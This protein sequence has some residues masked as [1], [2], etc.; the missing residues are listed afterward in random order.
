MVIFAI[1]C[2]SARKLEEK[3]SWKELD[4]AWPSEEAKQEALRSGKYIVNHN[5]P[6]GLDVWNDKLFITVPRWLL[7][8]S[9]R[10]YC[11][12]NGWARFESDWLVT[13]IAIRFLWPIITNKWNWLLFSLR[14][15]KTKT[16]GKVP[17]IYFKIYFSKSPTEASQNA[18]VQVIVLKLV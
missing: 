2:A 5:L 11:R 8:N 7:D 3:F 10:W 9:R 1:G 16:T 17:K 14:F 13:L 12:C 18:K 4:F 15:D 6:L